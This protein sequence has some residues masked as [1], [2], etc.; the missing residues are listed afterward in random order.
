MSY[1]KLK[2]NLLSHIKLVKKIEAQTL[3]TNKNFGD[4]SK[5]KSCL[6]SI[7]LH[8]DLTLYVLCQCKIKRSFEQSCFYKSGKMISQFSATISSAP[9]SK[10]TFG[11]RYVYR[12]S[13]LESK[14]NIIF[15]MI[16]FWIHETIFRYRFDMNHCILRRRTSFNECVQGFLFEKFS[17]LATFNLFI[18][19]LIW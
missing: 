13:C 10:Y 16:S 3:N 4:F 14:Q 15:H 9:D 11:A 19:I 7:T 17:V 1:F 12:I 5:L 18:S 6:K 8:W 2:D